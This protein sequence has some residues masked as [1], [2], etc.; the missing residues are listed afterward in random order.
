MHH[1]SAKYTGTS[2]SCH[3]LNFSM[4]SVNTGESNP[5]FNQRRT[6]GYGECLNHSGSTLAN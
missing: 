3:G 5:L 1:E 6:A 2:P 4:M